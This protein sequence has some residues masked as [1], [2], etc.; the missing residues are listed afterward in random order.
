MTFLDVDAP[1]TAWRAGSEDPIPVLL[2]RWAVTSFGYRFLTGR[3][4]DGHARTDAGFLRPGTKAMTRSGRTAPYNYWPGW[5]RGLLMTR[6][7]AFGLAPYTAVV[8]LNE[9]LE[10]A[11]SFWWHA[12]GASLAWLPHAAIG[13]TMAVRYAKNAGHERR[14]LR[15]LRGAVINVLRTREGVKLDIPRSLVHADKPGPTGRIFLPPSFVGTDNQREDL[16]TAVRDR[17]GA[18]EVAANWQM[19]GARP[20][21]ELYVPVQPPRRVTWEEAIER[22][23]SAAPYLGESASGRVDW[24]LGDDSPHA[25]IV[26]GSGSGKS[27]LVA[28]IVA[29]FMRGG[30]GVVVLDPKYASH[31]WLMDIPGV[32]YCTELQQL[33]DTIIWLSDELERRGRASQR[34]LED[35]PRLVVLVE[36]RNSLTARL[37]ELWAEIKPTGAPAKSPALTALDRLNDQGR[38]L[39]INVVLAAQETKEVHIGSRNS[40]GAFG[41]AGRLPAN[42]WRLVMGPGTSK[43][44]ISAKP[45]RFGWVVAG[46]ATVFQAAFPDLKKHTDRIREWALAGEQILDVQGLMYQD[47]TA[48]FPSSGPVT[49]DVTETQV[50]LSRFATDN[51]VGL[52]WL[53]SRRDRDPDFPEPIGV[54]AKNTSLY[55]EVDLSTWLIREREDAG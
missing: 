31:R 46:Q 48:T 23:D 41:I 20:S 19:E 6:L 43:P 54:G 52:S 16:L 55:R 4:L 44:G 36:E 47:G 42:A 33:H 49:T 15:P 25:A 10:V 12:G 37:R 27:E 29:Q 14:V 32:L 21:M 17:L 51:G 35:F 11:D 1:D 40:L 28:W 30:A 34:S 9:Q 26:G 18:Q 45:G 7:P 38:S 3:P 13:S 53:R 2:G 50:S 24:Q 39:G 22:A 8:A 5:K